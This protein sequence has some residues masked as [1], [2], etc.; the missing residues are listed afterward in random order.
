MGNYVI[1]FQ[2]IGRSDL[3]TAGGKGANLGELSKIEGITV[4]DGFCITTEAY[5]K[6][7][8]NNEELKN[9]LDELEGLEAENLNV[10]SE[11]SKK[12]R[13]IIE[14]M[15]ISKDITDEIEAFLKKFNEMMLLQ[16]DLVLLQK[17][18]LQHHLRVSRI[19]I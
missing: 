13:A 10:I 1:G 17:I 18:C 7:T 6:I 8:G 5:K 4:P 14:N 15:S 19:V 11:I 3:L 2:G 16:C 9:L 12:I